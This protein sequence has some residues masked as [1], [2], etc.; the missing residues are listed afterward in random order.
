MP[1]PNSA[2][3][4]IQ[5]SV[6]KTLIASPLE[7][8]DVDVGDETALSVED[9]DGEVVIVID[10]VDIDAADSVE[11]ML[12]LVLITAALPVDDIK[13]VVDLTLANDARALDA[14]P[15]L[16]AADIADTGTGN[17]GV[18]KTYPLVEGV[19]LNASRGSVPT[20]S[21]LPICPLSPVS[22]SLS[23]RA[24]PAC[25]CSVSTSPLQMKAMLLDTPAFI[26]FPGVLT[27]RVSNCNGSCPATGVIHLSSRKDTKM[28]IVPFVHIGRVSRT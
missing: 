25:R 3:Y 11:C 21:T 26:H 12:P 27:A 8:A 20:T 7:G 16:E 13:S 17:F 24:L 4:N 5:T 23:S 19:M 9:V 6:L 22:L 18:G 14:A 1:R 2:K 10:S 15:A 28:E